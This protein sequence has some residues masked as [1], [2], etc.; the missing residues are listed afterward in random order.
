MN[1]LL[2]IRDLCI[3]FDAYGQHR[4]VLHNVDLRVNEGERVS[5]IGQSGS[6]KT[7]TMRTI[8]GTLPM[9]P[10]K[11][12]QGSIHYN[13]Q[14][15]LDLNKQDRNRLKGTGISIVLQDPMLSFNPVLTIGR[16]MDDVI[17]YGDLRLGTSRSRADRRAHMIK[18]LKKV[19]LRDGGRVL[20]SYPMM[21]SGGMR[22]RVLIGMALLNKPRLLIADEPGTALDVTT[23]D[24]ILALLNRLV[25]EEGLSLLLI[26]H[27]LG[28]VR[29]MADRVYVMERGHIVETGTRDE[30]FDAPQHAYTRELMAAVPP[31]YGDGVKTTE[32]EG[33]QPIVDVA[34]VSKDFETRSG[35][36]NRVTGSFRAVNDVSL[37]VQQGDIFGI[38][39]ESGS[40]KT[41]LAKIIMGLTAP[42]RGTVQIDGRSLDGFAGTQEFRKLI[43]IVYQNPGS[44]LNPRRTVGDQLAVPLKFTGFDKLSI[45][46]RI[47]ELLDLVELPQNYSAM[48]PHEL[49]GG[50]KQRVAI[51]RA[52]SVHPKILVLDEPTSALDVLVQSTVI[53]LLHDLRREFDLTYIFISHDLSLM[54]NFCNRVAVMLRGEVVETGPVA[55]IFD[56]PDHPYTRAL[57]SAIPVISPEEDALKPI[58]SKEERAAVLATSTELE[59]T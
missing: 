5:L 57:L 34:S 28:V 6:G 40:G 44:S 35:W 12:E 22:Q 1:P 13:G 45:N 24:E 4:R 18:T 26:T 38:A 19:Q 7:V 27:N 47:S 39:G 17:R 14:S 33:T 55:E 21:L 58:V 23:Q 31:L 42:T 15:L 29:E 46:R 20:D 10:G 30:I 52:L 25:A 9:P 50:Q 32:H 8:I 37:T 54:R 53:D 49:S 36:L 41:T 16:Q 48:Y 3:G 59:D 11:V 51:A 56:T 2:D 43:Q